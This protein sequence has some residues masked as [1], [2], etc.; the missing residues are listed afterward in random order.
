M[1][2]VLKVGINAL[3][4]GD[5]SEELWSLAVKSLWM[6]TLISGTTR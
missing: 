2:T 6:T 1:T 5:P 3:S 4:R